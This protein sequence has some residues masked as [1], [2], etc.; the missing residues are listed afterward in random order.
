MEQLTDLLKEALTQT[1]FKSND[2]IIHSGGLV[3]RTKGVELNADEFRSAWINL[4][5][6]DPGACPIRRAAPQTSEMMVGRLVDHLRTELADSIDA[7]SDRIGHA[8]RIIGQQGGLASIGESVVSHEGIS[9]VSA[10]VASLIRAAAILGPKRATSM[11]HGWSKGEPLRSKTCIMMGG[12]VAVGET[13]DSGQGVRVFALPERSDEFPVAVPEGAALS[14]RDLL[15]QVVL[16]VD[17]STRPAIF[18]PEGHDGVS[19]GLF[20]ETA[21]GD[22][23][24]DTFCLALS[25]AC[26]R[27]IALGWSWTDYC[28]ARTFG[29]EDP[30]PVL[31]YLDAKIK[32][33]SE[34][35]SHT[36]ASNVTSLTGYTR[37]KPNLCSYQ[38]QK[39]LRL[40]GDLQRRIEKDPRFR[41]SVTR[42]HQSAMPGVRSAD[43]VIDLR[44]ALEALYL[45][46][47][48]GELAFRL[49]TTCARHLGETLGDRRRIQGLVKKFYQV[50]SRVI[51]ADDPRRIKQMDAM[52]VDDVG[53]L[54]RDGILKLLESG[55][56]P[57]W[58]DVLLR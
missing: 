21:L 27:R 37:P 5:W 24:L 6:G 25:L 33:V 42:W 36:I 12:G 57:D 45:D 7:A 3:A 32:R 44:I 49:A 1:V 47:S 22:V 30:Q 2:A 29:A 26:N 53:G 48:P 54:C 58:N 13:V 38:L 19:H 17:T 28:D 34:F 40:G 20:T 43:R 50:A 10:F 11:V 23:S 55:Q 18:R 16:E 4:C 14:P 52:L 8:F 46:P 9:D 31:R 15:G 39:S 41:T 51:H 35:T 56:K